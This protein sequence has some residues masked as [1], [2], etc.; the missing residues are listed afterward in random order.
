MGHIP[1][2][3]WLISLTSVGGGGRWQIGLFWSYCG[4]KERCEIYKVVQ[5]WPGLFV[6]KQVTVCPGHIWTTLYMLLKSLNICLAGTDLTHCR[7]ITY[8]RTHKNFLFQFHLFSLAHSPTR[9]SAASFLRLANHTQWHITVGRTPLDGWSARRREFYLAPHNT[10]KR[11]TS[12]LP[13]G[14]EP[15]T[16]A[17]DRPQTLAFDSSASY[18]VNANGAFTSWRLH[19]MET[20]FL[21]KS[22]FL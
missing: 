21:S 4:G 13:A 16:P 1:A 5:I 2:Q 6:C 3:S 22:G 12:M 15:A 10:H 19:L 9:A 20:D 14:L 7:S 17:S 8:N 11:Q 18:Y